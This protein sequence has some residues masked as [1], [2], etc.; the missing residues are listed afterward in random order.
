MSQHTAAAGSSFAFDFVPAV[1]S[2][3][4]QSC[5]LRALAKSPFH[6]STVLALTASIPHWAEELGSRD[7][8]LTSSRS[9]M[10][11]ASPH[12]CNTGPRGKTDS[13]HDRYMTF[14]N[15]SPPPPELG[16]GDFTRLLL[17]MFRVKNGRKKKLKHAV[18][19]KNP[20][21]IH[22]KN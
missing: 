4:N 9:E 19:S 21:V 6:A 5:S 11:S 18:L 8:D 3:Q 15:P 10:L 22:T 16:P 12:K 7:R 14:G 20:P 13:R 2:V 1:Y 17:V